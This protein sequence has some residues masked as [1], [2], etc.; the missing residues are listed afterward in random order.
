MNC[1]GCLSATGFPVPL[2][3]TSMPFSKAP[4]TIRMKASRSRWAGFMLAWILKM[5]P[6]KYGSSGPITPRSLSRGRGGGVNCRNRS[7]KGSTPKL[8]T[9][10]PKNMGVSSP[11][12]TFSRSKG[13]PASSSSSISSRSRSR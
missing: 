2:C 6:E 11:A 8:V 5:N 13:S 9:A 12:R 4:D 10:D 7:R 1:W 3:Q